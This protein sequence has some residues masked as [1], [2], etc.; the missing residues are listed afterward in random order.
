M[1]QPLGP[2]VA[3]TAAGPPLTPLVASGR[4]VRARA[5]RPE[6]DFAALFVACAGDHEMRTYMRYGSFTDPQA[7]QDWMHR[8]AAIH[9]PRWMVI[10][11]VATGAPV[12]MAALINHHPLHRRMELGHIWYARAARRTTTNTEVVLLAA[13]PAFGHYGVRRFEWKCAALNARSPDGG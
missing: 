7:L 8:A 9:D 11:S 12:G 13:D 2:L 3:L 10:E 4:D 5:P 1:P 6:D